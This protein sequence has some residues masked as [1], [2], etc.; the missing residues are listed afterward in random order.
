MVGSE[1]KQHDEDKS[2]VVLLP[3]ITVRLGRGVGASVT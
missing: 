1:W 3:P 2:K